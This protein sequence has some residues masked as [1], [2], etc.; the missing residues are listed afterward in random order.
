MQFN[1]A[2]LASRAHRVPGPI[3]KGGR[4]T[5]NPPTHSSFA[6]NPMAAQPAQIPGQNMM[7]PMPVSG[8]VQDYTGNGIVP[9]MARGGVAGAEKYLPVPTSP[10]GPTEIVNRPQIRDL[11]VTQPEAVVPLTR[12][13][14][15]HVRPENVPSLI[16]RY[17]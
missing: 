5:I 12:R 15:A 17:S 1:P 14:G 3:R 9:Q 4:R 11:G 16:R 8:N 13:A 2:K 6:D 10:Y 7:V